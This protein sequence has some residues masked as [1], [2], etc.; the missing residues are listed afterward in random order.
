MG[1]NKLGEDVL[2]RWLGI[3]PSNRLDA[4]SERNTDLH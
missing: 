3:L 4:D 2:Y 1:I